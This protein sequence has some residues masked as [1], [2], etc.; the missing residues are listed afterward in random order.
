[1]IARDVAA[2]HRYDGGRARASPQS[3]FAEAAPHITQR[4]L[5]LHDENDRNLPFVDVRRA[6]EAALSIDREPRMFT[7][8]GAGSE[9]ANADDSDPARQL[10]AHRFAR[11]LAPV[12]AAG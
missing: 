11:N 8:A 6:I 1:V 3:T 4:L 7:T 5:L 2:V 12:P 9:H 10:S